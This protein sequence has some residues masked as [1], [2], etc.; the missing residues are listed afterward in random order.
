MAYQSLIDSSLAKAYRLAK[1]LADNVTFTKKSGEFDFSTMEAVSADTSVVVKAIVTDGKQAKEDRSVK[2]KQ[3]MFRSKDLGNISLFD[4]V[5]IKGETWKLG[6][7]IKDS[8][9]IIVVEAYKE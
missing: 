1:D 6:N 8:G 7:V 9:Y 3:L 2:M 5:V 4:T